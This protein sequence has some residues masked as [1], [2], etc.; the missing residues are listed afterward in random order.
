MPSQ[1]KNKAIKPNGTKVRVTLVR[2]V[3]GV[4]E[5]LVKVVRALG[6]RKTNH[7]VEHVSSPIINGMLH[8]VSHLVR[9]EEVA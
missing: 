4:Q 7:S 3:I 1:A 9:V 6:L 8:K 5:K 2:S